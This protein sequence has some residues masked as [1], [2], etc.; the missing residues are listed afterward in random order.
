LIDHIVIA[1][2]PDD[3]AC[4]DK[5]TALLGRTWVCANRAVM[6]FGKLAIDIG[7][8]VPAVHAWARKQGFDQVVPIKGLEGFNRATA[9]SG[10]I[11]VDAIIGSNA[12]GVGRGFDRWLRRPSRPKPTAS[13]GQN[14][15]AT[16]TARWACWTPPAHRSPKP[17]IQAASLWDARTGLG[18]RRSGVRQRVP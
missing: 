1:S 10:P 5:L 17:W 11:F 4:W 12:C 6:L 2:G 13:Y 3:P 8:E 18:H 7:Y 14:D 16:R 15:R 9:V